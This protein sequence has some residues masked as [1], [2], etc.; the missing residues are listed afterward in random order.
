M[1][2]LK[3]YVHCNQSVITVHAFG[4]ANMIVC[5]VWL[6]VSYLKCDVIIVMFCWLHLIWNVIWLGLGVGVVYQTCKIGFI[7]FNPWLNMVWIIFFNPGLTSFGYPMK[8]LWKVQ[9]LEAS[10]NSSWDPRSMQKTL[11]KKALKSDC[12]IETPTQW[13]LENKNWRYVK[14]AT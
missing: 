12:W 11:P 5:Y 14:P 4:D 2:T 10:R 6:I 7:F 3:N 8:P 13:L 1:H 9:T